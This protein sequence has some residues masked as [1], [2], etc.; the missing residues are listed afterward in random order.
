[1]CLWTMEVLKEQ[2][3]EKWASIFRFSSCE[4]DEMYIEDK[5]EGKSWYRPD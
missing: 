3:R 2:T 1:M 4:F 5:L